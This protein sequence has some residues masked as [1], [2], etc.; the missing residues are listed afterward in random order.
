[1]DAR[2]IL[3]TIS[4]RGIRLTAAGDKIQYHGP[5]GAM[6][7][8]LLALVKDNRPEILALL[9]GNRQTELPMEIEA[10]PSCGDD[11][12]ALESRIVEALQARGLPAEVAP[13]QRITDAQKYA[14]A[15]VLSA[16]DP[17]PSIHGAARERLRV[18]GI[19][20]PNEGQEW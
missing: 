19:D 14:R 16:L 17:S 15:E 18:I 11:V 1:M 12:Q 9:T 7:A 2:E 13:G 3:D 6:T 10:E 20:G 8:E 4:E 5:D